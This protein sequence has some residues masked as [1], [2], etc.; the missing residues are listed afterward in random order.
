MRE[1]VAVG[2]H[3]GPEGRNHQKQKQKIE[4]ELAI[5]KIF[6][7]RNKKI[8]ELAAHFNKDMSEVRTTMY[9]VT[10]FKAQRK[11]TLRNSVAHQCSLDL[12]EQGITKPMPEL[13]AELE[14]ELSNGTFTYKSIDKVEQKH[15]IDQGLEARSY[16]RRGPRA[17]MRAAQVD[18]RFT[19][20]CIGDEMQLLDLFEHT[21]I[22]GFAFFVRGHADDPLHLHCIDSDD[23]LDFFTQG[24]EMTA[25]HFM[26][27]FEQWSCNLNEG[28]CLKNGSTAV[29]KDVSCMVTECLRSATKNPKV[30]MDYVNYDKLRAERSDKHKKRGPR[31][32]KATAKSTGAGGEKSRAVGSEEDSSSKEEDNNNDNSSD[33]ELAVR[34]TPRSGHMRS[35]MAAGTGSPLPLTPVP[36]GL[37][38][39]PRSN[40][41]PPSP[42]HVLLGRELMQDPPRRPSNPATCFTATQIDNMVLAP[43]SNAPAPA[44]TAALASVSTANPV[45]AS[46]TTLA[47]ISS[48]TPMPASSTVLAPIS[49]A[50]PAPA[51]TT[52]PAAVS[53]TAHVPISTTTPAPDPAPVFHSA[54]AFVNNYGTAAMNDYIGW[55]MGMPMGM[56][57][58]LYS[59]GMDGNWGGMDEGMGSGVYTPSPMW[60]VLNMPPLSPPAAE[61]QER[62]EGGDGE[63]IEPAKKRVRKENAVVLRG[64]G[65]TRA[66]ARVMRGG[67]GQGA[68]GAHGGPAP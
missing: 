34:P 28:T 27:K 55:D 6:V 58:G 19:A 44:S 63:H 30:K 47:P 60:P 33:E 4:C 52:T 15:L 67:R 53:N 20:K 2:T 49:S 50:T 61:K 32:G 40:S 1:P 36:V 22:C 43:I 26:R 16:A 46:S 17:T 65:R 24:L 56:G 51:S 59:R 42:G 29:R 13:Y 3:Q 54:Y 12:Q 18:G 45:P 10:Q 41:M 39:T 25:P 5:N 11:P 31:K 37:R 35:M 48:A 7:E 8:A 9:C 64:R 66:H 23:A 57:M 68:R 38:A 14:A 21:G 62:D